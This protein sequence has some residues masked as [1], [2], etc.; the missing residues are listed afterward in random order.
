MILIKD[1]L[2]SGVSAEEFHIPEDPP[3]YHGGHT[4][5]KASRG[6]R[7]GDR[8]G[9]K[10]GRDRNSSKHDG[11]PHSDDASGRRRGKKSKFFGCC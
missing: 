10:G 4:G 7:H 2:E 11:H 9:R 1:I 6:G 3:Q 5:D 8:G